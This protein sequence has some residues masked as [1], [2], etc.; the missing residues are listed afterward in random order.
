MWQVRRDFANKDEVKF[1]KKNFFGSNSIVDTQDGSLKL[2]K[3][4]VR[5]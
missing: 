5:I 4:S 3:S 1:V 2:Y